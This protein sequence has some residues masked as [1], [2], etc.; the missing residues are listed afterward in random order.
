[1]CDL[2]VCAYVIYIFYIA[3]TA[4]RGSRKRAFCSASDTE[5]VSV[6]TGSIEA[7]LQMY[8]CSLLSECSSGYFRDGSSTSNT[9]G[10]CSEGCQVGSC[11]SLTGHC[12]C[13]PGWTGDRCDQGNNIIPVCV[14][15][16]IGLHQ[17]TVPYELNASCL[18]NINLA[19]IPGPYL[20][21]PPSHDPFAGS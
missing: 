15:C 21:S 6:R 7:R 13:R 16:H 10:A 2:S 18:Y 20:T 14:P 9:C 1:M 3:V 17:Q 12:T 19:R 4:H 8:K 11:T 5:V